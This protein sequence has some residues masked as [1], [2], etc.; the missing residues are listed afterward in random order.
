[1]PPERTAQLIAG[2]REYRE[3][4]A[5]SQAA[6][7]RILCIS[8]ANMFEILKGKHSP[9][10]ETALHIEEL[11][12]T[13]NMTTVDQPKTLTA[14]KDRIEALT[15][16]LAQLKSKTPAA[17]AKIAVPAPAPAARAAAPPIPE[18]VAKVSTPP[19]SM[20]AWEKEVARAHAAATANLSSRPLAEQTV[21]ELRSALN[22]EKDPSVRFAI[23]GFLRK[24]K[25]EMDEFSGL[26]L[27]ND[28]AP[29]FDPASSPTWKP[30]EVS[31]APP[32]K[33]L[34]VSADTPVLIQKILDVTALD[35]DLLSML[36]NPVHSPLQRSMIY[37]EVK[38]RRAIEGVHI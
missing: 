33:S 15:A 11:L 3:R 22:A 35:P 34:P 21:E 31:H 5:I 1:V 36:S 17:P 2:L 12:R 16:E 18:A 9:N 37:S 28:Q 20:S 4:N 30:V 29:P 19:A 38:K 32:P 23:Y 24:R 10:A 26:K 25:A 27:S 14:A 6:L 7:A 13:N 8:P